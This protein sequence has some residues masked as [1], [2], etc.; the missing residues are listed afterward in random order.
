MQVTIEKGEG[1]EVKQ[2]SLTKAGP[3]EDLVVNSQQSALLA[4]G[5]GEH[6]S[7]VWGG[8]GRLVTPLSAQLAADQLTFESKFKALFTTS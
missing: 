7:P 2:V 1:P 6:G 8:G 5:E 4:A 3:R